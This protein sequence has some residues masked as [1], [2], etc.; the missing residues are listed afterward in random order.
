MVDCNFRKKINKMKPKI[1]K[2]VKI[3]MTTLPNRQKQAGDTDD[4]TVN[5]NGQ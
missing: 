4:N 1:N 3:Y 5:T 2:N